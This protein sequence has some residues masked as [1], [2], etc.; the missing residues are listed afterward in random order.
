LEPNDISKGHIT[1]RPG[2]IPH[3]LH[4][5]AIER[6]IGKTQTQEL[7]VMVDTFQPLMITENAFKYDDGKY[8]HSWK[9]HPNTHNP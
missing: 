1:F 6:S 7:P 4:L 9:S 5:D 2:A 8:S 3:G